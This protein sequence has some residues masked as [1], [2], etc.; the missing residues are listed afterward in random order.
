[1]VV[2]DTSLSSIATSNSARVAY[3]WRVFE[4]MLGGV[5]LGPVIEIFSG[6]RHIGTCVLT[7]T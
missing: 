4:G 6:R 3:D 2:A 5:N 7:L 1:M